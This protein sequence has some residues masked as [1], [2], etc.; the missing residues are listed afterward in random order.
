MDIVPVVKLFVK[1]ICHCEQQQIINRKLTLMKL[2]NY[3][4]SQVVLL[5]TT[6]TLILKYPHV[7]S[8]FTTHLGY[9]T[10]KR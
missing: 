10:K 6:L 4:S 5:G 1:L 3:P 7:K 9:P 2:E 8:P